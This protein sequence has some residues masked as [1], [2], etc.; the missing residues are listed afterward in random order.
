MKPRDAEVEPMQRSSKPPWPSLTEFHHSFSL[1]HASAQ[2]WCP[3]MYLEIRRNEGTKFLW[4]HGV[5]ID[6][7]LKF[8]DDQHGGHIATKLAALPANRQ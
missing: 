2:F 7:A 3:A 1:P 5:L 8:T 4:K 6:K